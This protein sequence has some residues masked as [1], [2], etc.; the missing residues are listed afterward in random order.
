MS[1]NS[2]D[3]IRP[4]VGGTYRNL[5]RGV[6]AAWCY[7]YYGDTTVPAITD[8]EN[9]SNLTDTGTGD[10]DYNLT[11]APDA[12]D[13]G[14]AVTANNKYSPAADTYSHI[15]SAA[16]IRLLARGTSGTGR[17]GDMSDVVLGDL[18]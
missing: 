18:A 9:V 15:D 11:N 6:S 4:S 8:S 12:A 13:N 10:V 1:N 3:N 5:P 7:V 17:D 2:A 14:A 16:V